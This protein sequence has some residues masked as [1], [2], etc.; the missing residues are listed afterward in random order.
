MQHSA[1]RFEQ[2]TYEVDPSQVIFKEASFEIATH[3]FVL[4]VGPSGCG[5]STLLKLLT[6]QLQA[7][8][9]S[10]E[11][12]R[13]SI[14]SLS[15]AEQ[16]SLR[17]CV[18]ML[19]QNGALFTDLS[20]FENVAFPLREHAK[21]DATTLTQAVSAQLK[22]VGLEHAQH[23]MPHQLSGGMTRRVAL[24]RA[25]ILNPTFFYDEPLTGQIQAIHTL[26]FS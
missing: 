11:V 8:S 23:L 13:Q 17:R 2:V 20:V 1:L 4:I 18:G 26:V 15:I 14:E 24:A 3:E 25:M 21:L 10:I 16:Q 6:G 19:F 22:E 9:G 5:K 7:E 12:L